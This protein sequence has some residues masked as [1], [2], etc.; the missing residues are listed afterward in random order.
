L[1]TK[2]LTL[3]CFTVFT[4]YETIFQNIFLPEEPEKEYSSLCSVQYLIHSLFAGIAGHAGPF[5]TN[6]FREGKT[7]EHCSPSGF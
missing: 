5:F 7:T 3:L 1:A 6:A 4:F 2:V